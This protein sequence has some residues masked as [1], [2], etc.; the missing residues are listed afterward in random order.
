MRGINLFLLTLLSSLAAANSQLMTWNIGLEEHWPLERANIILDILKDKSATN[1][2]DIICLTEVWAGPSMIKKYVTE[3][4]SIFPHSLHLVDSTYISTAYDP[5]YISAA[6]YHPPCLDYYT[7]QV[8]AQKVVDFG[9]CFIDCTLDTGK[10]IE[11]C[12]TQCLLA[13]YSDALKDDNKDTN[14]CWACLMES[15][16]NIYQYYTSPVNSRDS[17]FSMAEKLTKC[18]TDT[19]QKWNQTLGLLVLSKVPIDLVQIGYYPTFVVPRGYILFNASLSSSLIGNTLIGNTLIACTHLTP[20][21]DDLPY[22]YN[23]STLYHSWEEENIGSTKY[24]INLMNSLNSTNYLEQGFIS[25]VIMGDLNHGPTISNTT[26]A[27]AEE[28][29]RLLLEWSNNN[30]TKVNLGMCTACDDNNVYPTIPPRLYDYIW[31]KNDLTFN[32]FYRGFDT[33]IRLKV[34]GKC[35]DSKLSDHYAVI[36]SPIVYNN[37]IHPTFCNSVDEIKGN[38]IATVLFSLVFFLIVTF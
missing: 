12:G 11:I 27:I 13:T 16:Y 15:I 33:T 14:S 31:M 36:L 19:S 3:L 32:K 28:G 17:I 25:Q 26:Q 30:A 24:L 8:A 9:D 21:N 23:Y 35:Y 10:S 29:Y 37:S 38:L 5:T 7:D 4:N 1:D 2:V 34:N 18:Y 22:Q 20:I 6:V